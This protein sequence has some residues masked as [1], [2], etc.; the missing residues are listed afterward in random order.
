[1]AG[2]KNVLEMLLTTMACVTINEIQKN[3]KKCI[4][5]GDKNTAWSMGAK[6]GISP[7]SYRI[8]T[9]TKKYW[10]ALKESRP[11][12]QWNTKYGDKAIKLQLL[13]KHR[14]KQKPKPS[15]AL[16]IDTD[17]ITEE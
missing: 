6:K 13:E 9:V 12:Y 11:V 1:M 4:K 14:A 17:E 16:T 5:G 15:T 7:N 8:A 10:N 3:R 2:T